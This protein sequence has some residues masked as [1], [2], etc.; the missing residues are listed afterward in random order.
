MTASRTATLPRTGGWFTAAPA[1]DVRE[2]VRDVLDHEDLEH[3]WW[4]AIAS[5]L[6]VAKQMPESVKIA[7]TMMLELERRD[8]VSHGYY[9]GD[10]FVEQKFDWEPPV[11]PIGPKIV[12]LSS[13][14]A[15]RLYLIRFYA[16]IDG[17]MRPSP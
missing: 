15:K 3:R 17:R 4:I 5:A 1:A 8:L 11:P 9:S 16:L 6:C 10:V 13:A 12:P 7:D 2:R 14:E